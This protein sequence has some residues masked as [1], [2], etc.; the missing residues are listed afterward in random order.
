VTGAAYNAGGDALHPMWE[1][2]GPVS[3]FDRLPP[4]EEKNW[5]GVLEGNDEA[6][7]GVPVLR[8][9][10]C[11]SSSGILTSLGSSG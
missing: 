4:S 1:A 8:K 2:V 10:V 5:V 7:A 11:T 6:S 3:G 9:V